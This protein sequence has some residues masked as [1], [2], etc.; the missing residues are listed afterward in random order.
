M[1]VTA[2]A[3]VAE[4]VA[5]CE[6]AWE[7]LVAAVPLPS[8]LTGAGR[9]FVGRAGELERLNLLWKEVAAGERRVAGT[10]IVGTH[11]TERLEAKVRAI[12]Q[13][14]REYKQA[15]LLKTPIK[16]IVILLFLLMTL[17]VVFSFTWEG[18][19]GRSSELHVMVHT[20]DERVLLDLTGTSPLRGSIT[21]GQLGATEPIGGR[22]RYE[23][24]TLLADEA[25]QHGAA[26]SD[27]VLA[28]G[29]AFPDGLAADPATVAFGGV[30]VLG[31]GGHLAD[32]PHTL[33]WLSR[34]Q[35]VVDRVR[36]AGGRAA[37]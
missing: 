33:D 25:V 11:V 22:D 1:L 23:T 3:L 15:K 18:F 19:R 20:V 21:G 7:P 35:A 27:V 13:A 8:L 17:I 14:F 5:V 16:G 6:V 28:T 26:R 4:P 36:V 12:S 10:V 37:T 9:I 2:A 32:S 29:L 24:S 34:H 30:L 31:H